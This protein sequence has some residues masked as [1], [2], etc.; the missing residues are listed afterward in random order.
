[1]KKLLTFAIGL[2]ISIA[3]TK[4]QIPCEFTVT[5]DTISGE[6]TFTAPSEF[7]SLLYSFE[8]IFGNITSVQYGQ[9]V[10]NTYQGTGVDSVTLQIYNSD[11]TIACISAMAVYYYAPNAVSECPINFSGSPSNPNLYLFSINSNYPATWTFPDGST[12]SGFQTTYTFN[13]PGT[14]EVCASASG[15]GFI[16]NS[17]VTVVIPQDTIIIEEPCSASFW[18]GT[19]SLVGYF[20][21]TYNEMFN[22][23]SHAWGF[24]DGSSSTEQYP[25]HEY[26]APGYYDVCHTYINGS[27]SDYVCQTVYIPEYSFPPIDSTCN[28]DFII[29]QTNPYEVTIVNAAT[30][31]NLDFSWTLSGNGI[32]ITSSGAYPSL[33]VE[34]AG[35]YLFCLDVLNADSCFSSFC[36]S[37]NIGDDG[38]LGGRLS[39]AG[40]TINVVSPQTIT[41][42]VTGI[43]SP[44]LA[45]DVAI[46]PNPFTDFI[47]ISDKTASQSEYNVF[48]IE[49]RKVLSGSIYGTNQLVSVSSLSSG[50]YFLQFIS[51][52]GKI[53]TQKIVKK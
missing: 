13:G 40:F 52:E 38:A 3:S 33:Q 11:S 44:E 32:S 22:S 14:Y 16:C 46:F 28:A 17:C 48:T 18:A 31:N 26:T 23:S 8:W 39:A 10:I 49:G 53:S 6:Y 7:S 25:Y 35:D 47:T 15:G 41:G 50:I 51:K 20:V 37:I 24:G 1:M 43:E 29:T 36:D 12:Q 27:C 9:T 30:G 4:A 42:F 34:A 45:S 5:P 2:F 19:S 21:P